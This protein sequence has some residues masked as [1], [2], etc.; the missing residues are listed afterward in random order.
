[1]VG[2]EKPFVTVLRNRNHSQRSRNHFLRS[3]NHF[4]RSRNHF[5]R[6][7]KQSRDRTA[8]FFDKLGEGGKG[9]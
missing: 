6:Y 4:L 1:M 2:F 8:Y 3:R 5:L 7:R 9:I